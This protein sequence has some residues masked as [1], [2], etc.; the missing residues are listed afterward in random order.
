LLCQLTADVLGREVC[1]GPTESTALG[2]LVVQMISIGS[3]SDINE[4]RVIIGKSFEIKTF[5]PR[6]VLH[7]NQIKERWDKLHHM[8]EKEVI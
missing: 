1:A 6:W 5:A 7:L 8:T 3:I 2:N 4:A